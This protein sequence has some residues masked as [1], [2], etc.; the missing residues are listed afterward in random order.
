MSSCVATE[1]NECAVYA[2]AFGSAKSMHLPRAALVVE[3]N[4]LRHIKE[5][6]F[7]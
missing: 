2:R 6:R 5:K 1:R 3:Q 4:S 7:R